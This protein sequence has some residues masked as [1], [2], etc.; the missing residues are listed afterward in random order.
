MRLFLQRIRCDFV[1]RR[2]HDQYYDNN[3][4]QVGVSRRGIKNYPGELLN[5]IYLDASVSQE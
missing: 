5:E 2:I 4:D 1:Y 3:N